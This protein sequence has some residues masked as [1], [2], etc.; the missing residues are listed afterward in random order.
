MPNTRRHFLQHTSIA[1]VG[2]F[3]PTIAFA[4]QPGSGE[5]TV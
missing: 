5:L 3:L 1:S 4:S 2:L